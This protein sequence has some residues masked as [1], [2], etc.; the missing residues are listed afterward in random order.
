[1]TEIL[2]IAAEWE[3]VGPT[4]LENWHQ[5]RPADRAEWRGLFM[6]GAR[7]ALNLMDRGADR[8]ALEAECVAFGAAV[9]RR[10][11]P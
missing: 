8:E 5:V 11:K 6:M 10:G 3:R 9:A 1:V 2:T 4:I 7:T